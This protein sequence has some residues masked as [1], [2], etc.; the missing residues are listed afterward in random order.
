[1]KQLKEAIIMQKNAPNEAIKIDILV[2][3]RLNSEI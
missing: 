2:A 1:M 3:Q